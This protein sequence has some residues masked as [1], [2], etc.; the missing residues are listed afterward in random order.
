MFNILWFCPHHK[1][2]SVVL[3]EKESPQV[4]N[5]YGNRTDFALSGAYVRQGTGF[6]KKRFIYIRRKFR[7]CIFN[8]IKLINTIWNFNNILYILV[9][10]DGWS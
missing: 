7:I 4:Y 8:N 1:K 3:V 10:Y 2:K 9:L 5:K 6:Y